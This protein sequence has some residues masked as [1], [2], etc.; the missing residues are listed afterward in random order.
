MEFL[1]LLD[2]I[3]DPRSDYRTKYNLSMIIFCTFCAVLCGVETWGD[4]PLFCESKK[5]WL[6]KYVNLSNGIP[7]SWTFRRLF[8]LLNPEILENLLQVHAHSL[9]GKSSINQISIDGKTLRASGRHDLR[10]LHSV[11]A[12]CHEHGLTLAETSVNN[13]SNEITAI[14]LLLDALNIKGATITIDAAGCQKNIVDKIIESGGNYVLSLKK[15]HPK[16]YKKASEYCQSET[17][18]QKNCLKDYFDDGHGRLVRRRYFSY[19]IS[20]FADVKDWNSLKSVIAVETITSKKYSKDGVSSN[21][22]YYISNLPE[23][24]DNLPDLIKNHW[25]IENKLHWILDV[26]LKE[27]DDRKS[28][29]KSAKAF[30]VLK[31][32]AL[33]VVRIKGNRG[34]KNRNSI[35]S[36]IRSAGWNNNDLLKLL[37]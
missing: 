17:I 25:S 13:K 6:K 18:N 5:S 9:V 29:R 34:Y 37:L 23:N 19:N 3:E 2:Q 15:N 35:R 14:P 22:R 20:H 16:F 8:T 30:A 31:R 36:I 27:D 28:E 33:N 12:F 1:S 4:I 7:T 21:W 32:I 26:H 24:T 11:S 10:K